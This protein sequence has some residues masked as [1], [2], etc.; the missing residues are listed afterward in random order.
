MEEISYSI[1]KLIRPFD[2][3]VRRLDIWGENDIVITLNV[4]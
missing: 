3:F 2:V 1:L 4:N